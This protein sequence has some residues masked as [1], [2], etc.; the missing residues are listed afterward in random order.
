MK[1]QSFLK[2]FNVQWLAPLMV[3]FAAGLGGLTA[4]SG[5]FLVKER[6]GFDVAFLISVGFWAGLPWTIKVSI[7]HLVDIFWKYRGLIIC[8]AATL[9]GFCIYSM[10]ILATNPTDTFFLELKGTYLFCAITIPFCYMIQDAIADGMTVDAVEKG[11]NKETSEEERKNA[12]SSIQ[13]LGRFSI[14]LAGIFV[15]VFNI[16]FFNGSETKTKDQLTE[17]YIQ[18]YWVSLVI[19]ILS[20]MGVIISFLGSKIKE[21]KEKTEIN[22]KL[23]VGSLLLISFSIGVG[24]LDFKFSKEIVFITSFIV[25]VYLA[26][27]L[28]KNLTK[29]EKIT[30]VCTGACLFTFRA[31]PSVGPGLNWW[32]IDDLKFDPSFLA[33]LG[34]IGSILALSGIFIYK[35]WFSKLSI[36]KII[37]LLTIIGTILF[38]PTLGM[39][40]GLHIWLENTTGGLL[41]AKFIALVDETLTSPLMELAMIPMLAWISQTAP[42]EHKAA[43]FAT[44]ASLSNLALTL[45]RI[46]TDWLNKIWV[47]SA[48][49]IVDGVWINGNYENLGSL[50]WTTTIIGL[51]VPLTVVFICVSIEKIKQ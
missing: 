34:F 9:M 12:H 49:K 4:L 18:T 8:F 27:L 29:E 31:M 11:L 48:G 25:L 19:P 2:E 23:I 30:L 15:G 20:I 28:S 39:W 3:Y 36:Y 14:V 21:E 24:V 51:L 17:L 10:A 40:H 44:L 50:M 16:F 22:F 37:S 7:G 13:T 32:M 46:F 42:Y 47:V 35:L 6:F 33:K 41:G 43:W 45:S 38:L 5:T 1:K 26:K